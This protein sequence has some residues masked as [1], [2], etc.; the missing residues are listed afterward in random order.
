VGPI[1][2]NC[3]GPA[4]CGSH[5]NISWIHVGPARGS[6]LIILWAPREHY[7][8]IIRTIHERWRLS[9]SWWCGSMG[10]QKSPTLGLVKIMLVGFSPLNS[11]F[12]FPFPVCRDRCRASACRTSSL[13]RYRPRKLRASSV[14]TCPAKTYWIYFLKMLNRF[15]ENV[16]WVVRNVENCTFP[17]CWI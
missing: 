6:H 14:H 4:W 7:L 15:F 12:H 2:Q 11:N 8:W 1:N 17:I 16:D 10:W 5:T 13:C 3:V 9:F